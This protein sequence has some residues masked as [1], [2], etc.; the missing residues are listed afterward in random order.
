[1]LPETEIETYLIEK[2]TGAGGDAIAEMAEKVPTIQKEKLQQLAEDLFR[3][4][5]AS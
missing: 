5:N 4:L 3:R 1:M 2:T